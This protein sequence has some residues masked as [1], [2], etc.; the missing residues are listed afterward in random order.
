MSREKQKSIS[1]RAVYAFHRFSLSSHLT[2][3]LT[4]LFP[5][6]DLCLFQRMPVNNFSCSQADVVAPHPEL[7]ATPRKGTLEP[8]RPLSEYD[9]IAPSA[10]A[11][12]YFPLGDITFRFDDSLSKSGSMSST[13]VSYIN[14]DKQTTALPQHQYENVLNTLQ[15]RNKRESDQQVSPNQ[16]DNQPSPPRSVMSDAKSLFFGL[17]RQ[18]H[19]MDD[20]HQYINLMPEEPKIV[21]ANSDKVSA[22]SSA[23]GSSSTTATPSASPTRQNE[24]GNQRK[25]SEGSVRSKSP[26]FMLP[27]AAPVSPSQVKI[28]T[29]LPGMLITNSF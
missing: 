22:T 19:T 17:D 15:L 25:Y 4:L 3:T 8:D 24:S 13:A 2:A 28:C 27:E 26:K 23:S 1:F 21:S 20:D 5:S 7:L 29:H 11:Q 14:E 6:L 9:N 12:S 18:K 10:S 16:H